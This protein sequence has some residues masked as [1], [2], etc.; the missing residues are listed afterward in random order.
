MVSLFC[1]I[2]NTEI[3]LLNRGINCCH[4]TIWGNVTGQR[5]SACRFPQRNNCTIWGNVTG[6]RRLRREVRAH[7]I[8]PSGEMLPVKDG[9]HPDAVPLLLYHLG[10]CYRSKTAAWRSR[11]RNQL[12]HLGKCYRSK[13]RSRNISLSINCTIWGNVTG[14]R[15]IAPKCTKLRNCTIWGNVTGQRLGR[16]RGSPAPY[17]TIWGNVT[18]QRRTFIGAC[19]GI[20]CTIW[21]NAICRYPFN[22]PMYACA[23]YQAPLLSLKHGAFMLGGGYKAS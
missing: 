20:N 21:G 17:C 4:C 10:K 1:E 22:A 8:V 11:V 7:Q 5:R 16:G 9:E 13:T 2:Q 3:P 18:G 15:H 12:Y 14:Q 23:I 19:I 6:Q